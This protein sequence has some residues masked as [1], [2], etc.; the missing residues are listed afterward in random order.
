MFQSTRSRVRFGV[1][2]P[3]PLEAT[4]DAGRLTSD[5]G[6]VW[7]ARADQALALCAALARCVPEWRRRAMRHS[8]EDLVRQRVYQ[9][10]CGYADQNDAD[11]LRRDPLLKL[12]CGRLPESGA[13]LAS[14]PTFSR[15]E[16]AVDRRTIEEL[17]A[18]L[19]EVYLRERARGGA[20]E[21]IRIDLDGT[22]DPAHG[23]QE[24]VAYHG[25][26]RQHMYHPL[27]VSDGDTG[28]VITAI[29]RPGNAHGSCFVVL[30]L[31]RL[32]TRLR[33][34]WPDVRIEIRADSGFAT[35]RLYA[36][37]ER[38][39]VDYTIGIGANPRLTALAVPLLAVAQAQSDAQG[40]A[41]VRLVGEATYQAGSW[42]APRRLVFKTEILQK[43]PNVRFVVTS[44]PPEVPARAV[45]DAYV[46]RGAAENGPI[47]GFKVALQAD[48][49]SDHRFWANHFRLLLHLAA[50]WLLDTLRRWLAGTEA[51]SV[52]LDTLRLRLLKIAGRVRELPDRVRLH[53]ASSHPGEP[54]WRH[55][56]SAHRPW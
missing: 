41:K 37:C 39:A 6:L 7:L 50:Y 20:P 33:Q 22:D 14:Q 38:E 40:G 13:E 46:A 19:V 32:V 23:Q 48:R 10:A 35:P 31:R 16:N 30:V 28:Q 15:L 56:A 34:V 52:Q 53:L 1:P 27:L 24:G 8:L 12:V 25:Y 47:K 3:V 55:L 43:G 29:L 5:G 49:L 11:T 51:A 17:A 18:A 4:F 26:Y 54:L 36:W 9:I 45:Y 2:L 44:Q 21:R 42:P